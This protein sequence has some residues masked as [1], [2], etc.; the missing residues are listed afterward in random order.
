VVGTA[1]NECEA[2]ENC[3][4]ECQRPDLRNLW[5]RKVEKLLPWSRVSAW[6]EETDTHNDMD[7][8]RSR[9]T[10][11]GQTLGLEGGFQAPQSKLGDVSD[12]AA[13]S[14]QLASCNGT[15]PNS[16][17]LPMGRQWTPPRPMYL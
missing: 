17:P 3:R 14:G 10:G 13:C 2:D 5:G 1:R 15:D 8:C 7:L 16:W 12:S 6:Q 9:A 4:N 11:I